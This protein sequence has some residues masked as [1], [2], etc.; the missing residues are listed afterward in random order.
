M[1]VFTPDLEI[2]YKIIDDQHAQLI[3]ALNNLLDARLRRAGTDELL[4]TVDFLASYTERHFS[5]E[6]R[7]QLSQQYPQYKKHKRY[8]E[9]FKAKI[10]ELAAEIRAR[11]N[12][13][14]TFEKLVK[15]VDDWLFAHIKRE[16]KAFARY[17]AKQYG[18][19]F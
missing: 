18:E 9:R 1:Y 6:E 5:D 4:A 16:D 10:A 8:H 12:D 15:A 11:P 2:G 17:V 3:D 7:I 13:E 14:R 19:V